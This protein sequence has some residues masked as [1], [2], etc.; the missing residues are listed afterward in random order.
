M[1][2]TTNFLTDDKGDMHMIQGLDF[3]ADDRR[4]R[5]A[6][7]H[8]LKFTDLKEV[9]KVD[10][11]GAV[12]GTSPVISADSVPDMTICI[13]RD[14]SEAYIIY[15][16]GVN[17]KMRVLT[18]ATMTISS[19]IVLALTVSPL[20]AIISADEKI[21]W[22]GDDSK[23]HKMDLDGDNLDVSG[24][25]IAA[26]TFSLAADGYAYSAGQGNIFRINTADMSHTTIPLGINQT[27]KDSFILDGFFYIIGRVSGVGYETIGKYNTDTEAYTAVDLTALY[28][29]ATNSAAQFFTSGADNFGIFS[30]LI[31]AFPSLMQ[32]NLTDLTCKPLRWADETRTKQ[33]YSD[34]T[35]LDL[36][37]C[38]ID[39]NTNNADPPGFLTSINGPTGSV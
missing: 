18:I 11:S 22:L 2:V 21:I 16:D 9:V 35:G 26:N 8:S 6:D 25:L 10:S 28:G 4:W 19:E 39:I 29:V 31:G 24:V 27:I 15:L 23:L 33:I 20:R 30:C 36:V 38:I 7:G 3:S 14:E 17:T 1:G 13:N 5:F 37:R 12:V 34:N 32:C